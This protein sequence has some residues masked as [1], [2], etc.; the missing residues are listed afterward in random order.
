MNKTIITAGI[1]ILAFVGG[2]WYMVS[3]QSQQREEP[4]VTEEKAVMMDENSSSRYVEYSK[5]VLDQAVN[6]RRV[7]YFYASWCPTC[8]SADADFKANTSKIPKDLIVVRVNYNDPETDKEEKDLAE[9]YG[10]TYQHTFV[11][12]DSQGKEVTKWNGGQ[13]DELFANIK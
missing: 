2:G 11:Q 3:Q 8:R 4:K 7:L 5:T 12:I 1:V 9:K 10:I 6:N 13:T